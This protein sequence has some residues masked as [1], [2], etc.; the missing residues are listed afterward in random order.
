M[1]LRTLTGQFRANLEYGKGKRKKEAKE[2]FSLLKILSKTESVTITRR[3]KYIGNC[4]FG[5]R[6]ILVKEKDCRDLTKPC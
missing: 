1:E 6:S 3:E 4:E 5:K 2:N